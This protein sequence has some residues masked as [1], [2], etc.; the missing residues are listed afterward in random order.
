MSRPSPQ[1]ETE[2]QQ[3]ARVR[4]MRFPTPVQ[5]PKPAY[6]PTSYMAPRKPT[7]SSYAPTSYMAPQPVGTNAATVTTPNPRVAYRTRQKAEINTYANRD[8]VQS[9]IAQGQMPKVVSNSSARIL[10]IGED[11]LQALGYTYNTHGYWEKPMYEQLG[12][13]ATGG[14]GMGGGP[15]YAGGGGGGYGGYGDGGGGYGSNY[16]TDYAVQNARRQTGYSAGNQNNQFG[17]MPLVSWRI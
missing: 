10:G 8:Y 13:A 17:S 11:Q 5:S 2:E 7:V 16:P 1:G 6:A 15:V 12:A 9:A 4:E 3:W 14:A